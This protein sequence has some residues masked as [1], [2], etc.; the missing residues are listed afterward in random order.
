MTLFVFPPFYYSSFL[1]KPP[2]PSSSPAGGDPAATTVTR[3][4]TVE[5]KTIG[6]PELIDKSQWRV[7][8]TRTS[9]STIFAGKRK[10]NY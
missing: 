8:W 3:T 1:Q 10:C 7:N 5:L 2:S 6:L 9:Q 4:N